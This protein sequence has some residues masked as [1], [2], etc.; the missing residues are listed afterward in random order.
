MDF[1]AQNQCISSVSFNIF[2]TYNNIVL[3]HIK[4]EL[5]VVLLQWLLLLRKQ[6]IP[7]KQ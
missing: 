1:V 4:H 7:T 5:E 6:L 2:A 3:K